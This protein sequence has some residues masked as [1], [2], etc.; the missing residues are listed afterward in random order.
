MV[1]GSVEAGVESETADGIGGAGTETGT[2]LLTSVVRTWLPD[3]ELGS[4]EAAAAAAAARLDA[5]NC[6]SVYLQAINVL[7]I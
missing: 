5:K 2:E 4:I 6:N 3:G 1:G 7:T